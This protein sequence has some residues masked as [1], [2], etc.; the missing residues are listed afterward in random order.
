MGKCS[1]S[2]QHSQVTLHLSG[3]K[4]NVAVVR[5]KDRPHKRSAIGESSVTSHALASSRFVTFVTDLT[6]RPSWSWRPERLQCWSRH[7]LRMCKTGVVWCWCVL[8]ANHFCDNWHRTTTRTFR[9]SL[10]QFFSFCLRYWRLLCSHEYFK[11]IFYLLEELFSFI[12]H[13]N[14]HFLNFSTYSPFLVGNNV[15]QFIYLRASQQAKRSRLQPST[16]ISVQYLQ[17]HR[18]GR[19][20][21]T[22]PLP[23]LHNKIYK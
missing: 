6:G 21:V 12:A 19:G 5:L 16:K 11:N 20:E 1:V 8:N 10:Q 4:H 7:V 2:Q 3:S 22:S 23:A 9:D 13:K 15:V 18:A 17:T 14:K